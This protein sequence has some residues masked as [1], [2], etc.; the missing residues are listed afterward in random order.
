MLM[1][2]VS[3]ASLTELMNKVATLMLS[4]TRLLVFFYDLC[5]NNII[6]MPTGCVVFVLSVHL[7]VS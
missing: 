6:S 4:P 5:N 1:C 2:L 7:F 3:L